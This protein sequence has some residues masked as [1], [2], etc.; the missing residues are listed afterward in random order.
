M[1]K[2]LI[3]STRTGKLDAHAGKCAMAATAVAVPPVGKL[4]GDVLKPATTPQ[5]HDPTTP[6]SHDAIKPRRH[7]ATTPQSHDAVKPRPHQATTPLSH[8]AIK[9]RPHQATTPLSH[10]ATLPEV[11]NQ[12]SARFDNHA[13]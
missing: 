8:D 11:L 5:R 7:E 2:L 9:P 1:K 4:Q 6:R 12:S 13:T 10:D 3:S